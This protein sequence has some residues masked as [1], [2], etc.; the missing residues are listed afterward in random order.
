MRVVRCTALDKNAAIRNIYTDENNVKWVASST[1]IFKIFSADNAS[2]EAVPPNSWSLLRFKG[3]NEIL[4]LA[5][6]KMSRFLQGDLEERNELDR[7]T[8]SFFDKKKKQLW[9]GTS[10]S[11]L[12]QFSVRSDVQLMN[13]YTTENSKLKSNNI[14]TILIDK[15]GRQWIGTDKGVIY[16]SEDG[17]MKLYEKKDNIIAITALGPDVWILTDQ[18]LWQV[19][20][21]NRWIKGNVD[22]RFAEGEIRDIE[23][24][25]EG[26]LWVASDIIV[27]YD[28]VNDKV[29]RFTKANGFASNEINVITIDK[30]DAL[31]VG[32]A[33]MGLF[34]IEK[35][36]VMTVSCEIEK[37][38]SCDGNKN[39]ATLR[40]KIIGGNPPFKY[41][42]NNGQ[43]S[44]NP[45]NL[46]PGQYQVTVTDIEGNKRIAKAQIDQ[47]AL[48]AQVNIEA[49]ASAPGM[50]DGRVSVEV[51]GGVPEYKYRWDNGENTSTASNLTPGKHSLTITDKMRCSTVV[52]VELPE[53]EEPEVIEEEVASIDTLVKEPTPEPIEEVVAETP[54]EKPIEQPVIEP[55]EK[56]KEVIPPLVVTVNDQFELKCADETLPK[57]PIK[58]EGGKPPYDFIWSAAELTRNKIRAGNYAVTVQD[59]AQNFV[60]KKFKVVAPK[61]LQI[62]V[63]EQSPVSVKGKRDGIAEASAKGGTAPYLWRWDNDES[64]AVAK[65]LIFGKHS[66][67]VTDAN[68]CEATA[69]VSIGEKAVPELSV[70]NIRSGQTIQ[71]KKLYFQSDS[72]NI[73]TSSLPTLDEVFRFLN[74]NQKV[75]VE[76]GGHTNDIPSDEFCDRLSTARAK[77]VADY[78]TGKGVDESR[79]VYKGYGKRKPIVS[80]RTKVGRAKNQRVELKILSLG[81]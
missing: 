50:N 72:S 19:N 13:H 15:Y 16:G 34:L 32:T 69:T 81:N 78:L 47:V 62:Q 52:P 39:D 76:V 22:S 64:K 71:L 73:E 70:S 35:E 59:A 53:F 74:K 40:V 14:N 65:K 77:A 49:N 44:D 27:R 29:E 6:D 57:I 41:K 61:P 36:T 30:E 63:A 55:F 68:G 8:S 80:N 21:N 11:G 38:L 2:K 26:R 24:D 3:G 56:P 20:P 23:Y 18:L 67:S 7:V 75:V 43:T 42:W 1:G 5:K 31:W 12:F 37:G 46:G 28:V 60:E 51:S 17:S 66:L 25:S 33:D 54:V 58:V 48:I 79:V 10:H 4:N 45:T 9:V